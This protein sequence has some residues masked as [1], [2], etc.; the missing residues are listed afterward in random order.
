M[1]KRIKTLNKNKN[2]KKSKIKLPK[3]KLPK[4][5]Y[6]KSH[7]RSYKKTHKKSYKKSHKKGGSRIRKK[8]TNIVTICTDPKI[9]SIRDRYNTFLKI[10]R[11]IVPYNKTIDGQVYN[12]NEIAR[13][14]VTVDGSKF[15]TRLVDPNDLVKDANGN[16]QPREGN[17]SSLRYYIDKEIINSSVYDVNLKQL[18]NDERKVKNW[19]QTGQCIIK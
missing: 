17:K 15:S 6:K 14:G 11:G 9:I 12:T 16:L 3:K 8:P 2:K 7:K 18:F 4:R 10:L 13:Y 19:I 5:S 1:Q